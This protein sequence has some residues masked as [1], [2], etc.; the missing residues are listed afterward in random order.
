M[1][2]II[3][4]IVMVVSGISICWLAMWGEIMTEAVTNQQGTDPKIEE[5]IKTMD[6][7]VFSQV[8]FSDLIIVGQVDKIEKL[9]IPLFTAKTILYKTKVEIKE[10]LKGN[11]NNKHITIF[12][13][14]EDWGLG[15]KLTPVVGEET[16]FFIDLNTERVYIP[17]FITSHWPENVKFHQIHKRWAQD[18]VRIE[19]EPFPR[20]NKD[21][22]MKYLELLN[23]ARQSEKIMNILKE[24]FKRGMKNVTNEIERVKYVAGLCSV[25]DKNDI[26]YLINF[27]HDRIGKEGSLSSAIIMWELGIRKCEEVIETLKKWNKLSKHTSCDAGKIALL[28]IGT[29]EAMRAFIEIVKRDKLSLFTPWYIYMSTDAV[30]KPIID[31]LDN[32]DIK[33]YSSNEL[34]FIELLGHTRNKEAKELLRKLL[35]KNPEFSTTILSALYMCGEKEMKD[36]M[37][38]MLNEKSSPDRKKMMAMHYLLLEFNDARSIPFI[39]K[40]MED[41]NEKEN[42]R[43][44]KSILRQYRIKESV[45]HF[46]IGK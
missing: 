36:I 43:S 39:E 28:Q 8:V 20:V 29:N 31:Y 40:V 34:N 19:T 1:K 18:S 44:A 4:M 21:T 3:L 46:I 6:G 10:T 11:F 32:I 37:L 7:Y 13:A 41:G 24:K 30:I 22:I 5:F 15:W 38:N 45:K 9:D 17:Y 23:M 27:L 33:D 35:N 12:W 16:I 42:I 26:Q 14:P 2:R 25:M